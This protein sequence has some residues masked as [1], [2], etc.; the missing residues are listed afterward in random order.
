MNLA[1]IIDAHPDGAP[2]LVDAARTLTYG[3]LRAEVAAAR[4]GLVGAGVAPGDRVALSIG[5]T[6]EFPVAFLAVVSAGAVAVPLNPASPAPERDAQMAA[7][8]AAHLLDAVPSGGPPAPPVPREEGDLACLLFTAGTAGA[9]RAAMLTHGNLLANQAQMQAQPGRALAATD[10]S[11]GVIPLFHI[12]GLNVVL[13]L[14]LRAGGAVALAAHFDPGAPLPPGVTVV[15]GVPAMWRDWLA[16]QAEGRFS[17]V[18]LALSGA[19]ALGADTSAAW[20]ARGLVVHEGYGLTEAGPTVTSSAGEAVRDGSIGVPLPGVEVRLVGADGDD[21][22]AGDEGEVWVRGPNVFA[23]YWG[24]E[25][26]T[27]AALAPEGWLRTGDIAVADADGWL[28][29]V[30]RAKDVVNVSGFKVYPAEVEDVLAEHPSVADAAVVGA[31]HPHSGETVTAFVV[32]RGPLTAEELIRFCAA[33]LA[34]YK[35]PTAVTFVDALPQ[36][37][38]GKVLRRQLRG[39]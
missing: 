6:W 25:G 30:D 3:D 16:A 23:G 15:A 26:A 7:V 39:T 22:L 17:G 31:P 35:C 19:A 10:V 4:A 12:F 34:R 11:L 33:R 32:A 28:Y 2:A 37:V 14:T 29:L 18:R 9:P 13:L 36:G 20:R 38:A 27:R 1:E 24:D 8:G 21:V 5:N